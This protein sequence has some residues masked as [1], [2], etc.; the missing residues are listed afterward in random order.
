MVVLAEDGDLRAVARSAPAAALV[1]AG[2]GVEDRCQRVFEETLFPRARI[3]GVTDS[4]QL[5]AVIESIVL[6][7]D[8]RHDVIAMSDGRFAPR[9]ACLGRGGVRE[10]L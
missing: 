2:D 8:E 9:A 7:R 10:L 5:D 6:E 1:V 4:D 3:V